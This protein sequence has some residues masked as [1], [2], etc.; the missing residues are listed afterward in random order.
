MTNAPV[1]NYAHRARRAQRDLLFKPT[2]QPEWRI[3]HGQRKSRMTE[4]GGRVGVAKAFAQKGTTGRA[5][6]RRR[7][8]ASRRRMG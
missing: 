4:D 2:G 3:E 7:V 6:R 5:A 8:A 1:R